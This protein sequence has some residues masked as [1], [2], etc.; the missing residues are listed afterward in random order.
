LK[1]GVCRAVV[2]A[3]VAVSGV[4]CR[5]EPGG[6]A[7]TLIGCG[8]SL[9]VTLEPAVALP[10]RAAL[11]FPGGQKVTFQCTSAGVQDRAGDGIAYASCDATTFQVQ[12][13]AA[14]G[15][16]ST[17]PVGVEVTG[18]DGGKRTGSLVPAYTSSQPNG[19]DCGPTC[20]SGV[21]ALR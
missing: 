1:L 8:D 2:L 17:S 21:A 12:C 20:R 10:Y 18:A 15:Y 9:R 16:C 6:H 3:V 11:S 5:E 19:P 4:A 14:P 7:C 13:G